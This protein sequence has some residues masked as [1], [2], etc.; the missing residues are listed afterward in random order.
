MI[1]TVDLMCTSL[2]L[3]RL[4]IILLLLLTFS[5]PFCK[6][7]ILNICNFPKK[8]QNFSIKNKAHIFS[9]RFI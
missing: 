5:I 2:L 6:F 4:S 3:L 8:K 7:Y 9:N 1:T